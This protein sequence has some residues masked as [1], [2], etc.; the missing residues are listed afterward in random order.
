MIARSPVRMP[1]AGSW[2]TDGIL[3]TASCPVVSFQSARSVK[4][5]PTSTPSRAVMVTEV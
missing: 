4:V 2:G 5:P 1:S 3:R